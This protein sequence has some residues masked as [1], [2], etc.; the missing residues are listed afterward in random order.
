MH[1]MRSWHMKNL[2]FLGICI[3]S[4]L[5]SYVEGFVKNQATQFASYHLA[6]VRGLSES[7][8]N[9]LKLAPPP[10]PIDLNLAKQQHESYLQLLK[11]LVEQVI[12]LDADPSHPD[13]NFIEDTAIVVGEKAVISR[14]GALERRGEELPVAQ[15]ISNLGTKSVTYI[16]S[17]G[18]MDGGDILYTGT[19]LFVGLSRRT[20]LYALEQLKEVFKE[21]IEVIGIPVTEGLHLKSI[22]TALDFDTLVVAD[23]EAGWKVQELISQLTANAYAFIVVPD[24]V[25]ANVLRINSYLIV[26]EGYPESEAILYQQC[27]AKSLNLVTINMSELIKADGALTCG[28]ILLE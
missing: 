20:N 11:G 14:M 15:A 27:M 13:C 23:S 22:L 28:S 2:A 18:I 12:E 3:F 25:A 17:P 6:L 7:F 16:Q 10:E 24:S 1:R 8:E 19:H 5:A 9:S 4:T 21:E 26:Q